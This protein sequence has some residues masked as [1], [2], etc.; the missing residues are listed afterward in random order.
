MAANKAKP[1][2]VMTKNK[3]EDG[4]K[5]SVMDQ[6][7]RTTLEMLL[8]EGQGREMMMMLRAREDRRM[9]PSRGGDRNYEIVVSRLEVAVTEAR[10]AVEARMSAIKGLA[11]EVRRMGI[12]FEKVAKMSTRSTNIKGAGGSRRSSMVDKEEV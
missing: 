1:K 9:L 12:V 7:S 2:A 10:R 6:H 3:S 4:D 5:K 8:P 11:S